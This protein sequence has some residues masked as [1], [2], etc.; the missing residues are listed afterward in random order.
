LVVNN[1]GKLQKDWSTQVVPNFWPDAPRTPMKTVDWMVEAEI[2]H[3]RFAMLAV[4]GWVAVDFG[5]RM[6]GSGYESIP[7]SLAAHTA[8]VS[9]GSLTYV[10]CTTI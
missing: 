4:L 6:P 7:N 5:V 3:G 2:K 8:A 1:F 9:N 10:L